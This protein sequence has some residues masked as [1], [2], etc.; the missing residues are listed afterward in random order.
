M[1][2]DVDKIKELEV[3]LSTYCNAGCPGCSRHWWG[4]SD[5]IPNL[6]EEHLNI[7][8]VSSVISQ[9]PDPSILK[10]QLCGNIGD[11]MMNP[12]VLDGIKEWIFDYNVKAIAIDTN[13]G[14]RGES[15]WQELAQ[16]PRV[17]VTF[18]IDGMEDTNHIYRVGVDWNK[19]ERN[20]ITFIE[21]G[22]N[23]EWKFLI[24][25]HNKHQV[26]A[27]RDLSRYYGFT[28]FVP[29][30]SMREPM[31]AVGTGK[32]LTTKEARNIRSEKI[33]NIDYGEKIS[34]KALDIKRIYLNGEGRIWPCCYTAQRYMKSQ[35]FYPK[36]FQEKNPYLFGW[37]EKG[38]NEAKDHS[39]KDIL[40]HEAFA[41][42][43]SEWENKIDCEYRV[44]W[45]VC[46]GQ[47]WEINNDIDQ[48]DQLGADWGGNP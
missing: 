48:F 7:E 25:E 44:C 15:F 37:Y 43:K 45:S 24:F 33:D 34:C 26:L 2:I 40:N 5:K 35:A 12:K 8:T 17:F 20:F 1:F 42:I 30:M 47:S 29:K 18:S 31:S 32:S 27:A 39:L 13:G 6:V 41:H 46:K 14:L 36:Q 23:A 38:F 4:T 19:L 11:P 3:E 16:I 21:N 10:I 28:R 9:I 22:G